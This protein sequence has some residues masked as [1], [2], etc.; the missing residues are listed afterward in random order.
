[1]I[2]ALPKLE[3]VPLSRDEA[4]ALI[5]RFH[6]HHK[7]VRVARFCVGAAR[8]GEVVA[9]SIVGNPKARLLQNGYTAEVVRLCSVDNIIL[10]LVNAFRVLHGE[11]LN[12]HASG[13]CSMLYAACWRAARAMGFRKL[14]TY[15]LGEDGGSSLKGAGWVC[16]G[17]A[18]GGSWDRKERPRVD[19]HPLQTKLRWE[20]A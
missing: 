17:E 6:R 9:V 1:M 16:I 18:G 20:A 7:P 19:T 15:I 11:D 4:N 10:A 3:L 13:A 8:A 2:A 5:K 12:E 14:V